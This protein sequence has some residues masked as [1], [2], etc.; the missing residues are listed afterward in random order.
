MMVTKLDR[1]ALARSMEIAMRNPKLAAQLDDQL[2]ERPWLEVAEF[3]SYCCQVDSLICS[4]TNRRLA[5]LLAMTR[6]RR[7]SCAV[8]SMP[9]CLAM[10]QTPLP[11]CDDDDVEE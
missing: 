6:T 9:D 7:T 1:E 4:H 8:S 2:K 5:V 3:A 11:R 10:S